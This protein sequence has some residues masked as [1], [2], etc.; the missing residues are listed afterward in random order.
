MFNK[1]QCYKLHRN[2]QQEELKDK[3]QHLSCLVIL[4]IFFFCCNIVPG[5]VNFINIFP[6]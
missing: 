3:M 2:W 1:H 5:G 4:V 6:R